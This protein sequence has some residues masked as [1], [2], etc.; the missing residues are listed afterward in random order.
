MQEVF[1]LV[2]KSDSFLPDSSSDDD[3]PMGCHWLSANHH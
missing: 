2:F 1:R 3:V